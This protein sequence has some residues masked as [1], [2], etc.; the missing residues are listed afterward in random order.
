ML[1]EPL[2]SR[3]ITTAIEDDDP[4]V[5][6]ADGSLWKLMCENPTRAFNFPKGILAMG[7]VSPLSPC[8]PKATLAGIGESAFLYG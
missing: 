2:A 6:P 4:S 8:Q 7:G 3:D 5:S 1:S